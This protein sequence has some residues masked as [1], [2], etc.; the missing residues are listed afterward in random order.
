MK[1]LINA[2][3]CD[4]NKVGLA[5][6]LRPE[7]SKIAEKLTGDYGGSIENLWID[8]EL[9]E[10]S[11]LAFGKPPKPFRYQKRVS[12]ASRMGLPA[13]PDYYNV[14]HYSVRPDFEFLKENTTEQN[15]NYI[16]SLIYN[17]TEVL[18]SKQKKLGGFDAT[19]FRD[20]FFSACVIL[21]YKINN[22]IL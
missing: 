19:R 22:E 21:G 11:I 9:S 6:E 1:V 4:S 3:I 5:K 2:N 8:L 17:S 20:T 16:V 13:V 10:M 12:G 14:G 18:L 15:I 7:F